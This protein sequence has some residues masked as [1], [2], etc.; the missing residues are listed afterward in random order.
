MCHGRE[1]Q[2]FDTVIVPV[3]V[4]V[5]QNSKLRKEGKERKFENNCGSYYIH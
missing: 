3:I 4:L 5:I 2:L 1:S